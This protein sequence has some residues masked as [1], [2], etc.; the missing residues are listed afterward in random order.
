MG[1]VLQIRSC[2]ERGELVAMLGDRVEPAERG[3]TRAVTLLGGRI[4]VPE[5]PYLL[6]GLL[7][8][9][10]FFMVA[11]RE[12]G[13]ALPRVRGGA[14][15][16][17]RVRA[18]GARQ[19]DPRARGGLCR[20]PRALPAARALPMVQL[21]RRV[22]GGGRGEP[23]RGGDGDVRDRSDRERLAGRAREPPGR[24]LRRWCAWTRGTASPGCDARRRAGAGLRG[25]RGLAAPQDAQHGPRLAARHARERARARRRG[26]ARAPRARRRPHRRRLRLHA[27]QPARARGL[28][29]P[30]LRQADHERDPRQRLH[31]LH[32][33]HLRRRTSRSSSASAGGSSRPRARAP[34]AARGSAMRT[35]RSATAART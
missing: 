30:V 34:R 23:P 12:R 5:A 4:E 8:C 11:L 21:L 35:R 17:G 18:R 29:A 16:P 9:P 19:A 20:P 28:R 13:P 15:R 26:P 33:P 3:R 10:L 32:E 7:E 6:A 24:P 2:I 31:P 27:G 25:A 1:T 14:G 22:G